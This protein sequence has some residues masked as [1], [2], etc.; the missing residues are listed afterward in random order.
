M[1]IEF[2]ENFSI[3]MKGFGQ[4]CRANWNQDLNLKQYGDQLKKKAKYY[5]NSSNGTFQYFPVNN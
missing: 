4:E 3:T 1:K 2:L 5:S